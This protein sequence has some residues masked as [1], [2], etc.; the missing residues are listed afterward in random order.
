MMKLLKGHF[1]AFQA[2]QLLERLREP[3]RGQ[4]HL[5][6]EVDLRQVLGKEQGLARE[7]TE[8]Q[9]QHEPDRKKALSSSLK[10]TC[11]AGS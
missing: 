6:G 1:D 8:H 4:K 10:P 2:A 9:V 7:L 3:L 5:P 11:C